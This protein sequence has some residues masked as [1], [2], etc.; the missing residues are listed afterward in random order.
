LAHA[1]N[2]DAAAAFI[3]FVLSDEAQDILDNYGFSSP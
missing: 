2:P 1:P 3:A